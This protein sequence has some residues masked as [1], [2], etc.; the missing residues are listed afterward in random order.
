M[1]GVVMAVRAIEHFDIHSQESSGVPFVDA[2]L[3]QARCGSVP[4]RVWR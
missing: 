3:H 1:I 2:S 4:K